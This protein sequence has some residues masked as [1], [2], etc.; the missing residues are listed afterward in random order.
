LK[1]ANN[2]DSIE[3]FSIFVEEFAF[4]K[5]AKKRE[6]PNSIIVNIKNFNN[7]IEENNNKQETQYKI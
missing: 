6:I 3:S 7:I 5:N 2:N 4:K 1:R